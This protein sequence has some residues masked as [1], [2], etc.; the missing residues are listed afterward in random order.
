[1]LIY[2]YS[3][4]AN[5]PTYQFTGTWVKPACGVDTLRYKQMKYTPTSNTPNATGIKVITVLLTANDTAWYFYEFKS[6]NTGS[7]SVPGGKLLASAVVFKPGYPFAL[8]DTITKTKNNFMFVS[9]EEK[10]TNTYPSYVSGLEP[11]F[12]Y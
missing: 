3:D 12:N 7:F 9:N 1:L 4:P 6:F 5:L 8:G 10:G 2:L 11:V